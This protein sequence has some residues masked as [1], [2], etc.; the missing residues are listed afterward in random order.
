[1]CRIADFFLPQKYKQ[2][3]QMSMSSFCQMAFMWFEDLKIN[4]HQNEKIIKK[5]TNKEKYDIDMDQGHVW[6]FSLI[7]SHLF[8]I[9]CYCFFFILWQMLYRF[10]LPFWSRNGPGTK[11]NNDFLLIPKLR[12]N[13]M[14]SWDRSLIKFLLIFMPKQIEIWMYISHNLSEVQNLILDNPYIVLHDSTFRLFIN[15]W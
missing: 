15:N 14:S 7:T 2:Q 8:K 12:R 10:F 1:M 13:S 3:L 11:K 5:K 9:R 6:G 4:K